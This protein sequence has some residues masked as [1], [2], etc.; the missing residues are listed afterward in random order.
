MIE[1]ND[2]GRMI[3]VELTSGL[4]ELSGIAKQNEL[5][6][7]R[8]RNDLDRKDS[9]IELVCYFTKRAKIVLLCF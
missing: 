2:S 9:S 8:R 3:P 1:S 5:L 6:R 4:I 7:I